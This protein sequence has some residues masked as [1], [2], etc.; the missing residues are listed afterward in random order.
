MVSNCEIVKYMR[1]LRFRFFDTEVGEMF[2]SFTLRETIQDDSWKVGENQTF[3]EWTGKKIKGEDLFE[4][5]IV[6]NSIH[7]NYFEVVWDNTSSSFVLFN[8]A[9]KLT[10]HL[11]TVADCRIAGNRF[12]NPKLLDKVYGTKEL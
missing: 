2:D 5:D 9:T 12:E 10:M 4:G 1:E 6:L 3:M 11:K 7:G 8:G